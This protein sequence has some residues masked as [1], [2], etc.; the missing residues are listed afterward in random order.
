[1]GS[2]GDVVTAKLRGRF[3]QLKQ[4]HRTPSLPAVSPFLYG[5]HPLLQ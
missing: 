3:A 4:R 1:M 5:L 2:D